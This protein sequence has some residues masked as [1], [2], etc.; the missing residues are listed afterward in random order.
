MKETNSE[1]TI[2]ECCERSYSVSVV[3]EMDNRLRYV[4]SKY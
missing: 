2:K 4:T 1:R 3:M